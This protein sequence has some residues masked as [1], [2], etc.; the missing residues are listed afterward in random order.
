[1][2]VVFVNGCFDV[3]HPGHIRLFKYAKSLGD[4][5]IVA[6][7]S[8]EKVAEDKGSDRP[9][10]TQSDRVEILEAIRYI[11]VVHTFNCKKGLEDLLE[12]IGPDILIVGSDWKGK[13]VV[14]RQYAKEVRFFDR[15]GEYSTTRTIQGITYR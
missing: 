5:L 6:I 3:L 14:G 2:K 1:M 7:D 4:Y 9:I 8:D 13:E 15:V 11:D 10:F 12:L